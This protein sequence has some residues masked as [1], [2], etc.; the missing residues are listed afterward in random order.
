MAISSAIL[1]GS[2]MAMTF[3]KMAILALLVSF[4][5]TAASRFTQGFIHQ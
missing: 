4:A 2:L 5:M 3:P 1:M